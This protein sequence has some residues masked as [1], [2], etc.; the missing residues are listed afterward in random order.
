MSCKRTVADTYQAPAEKALTEDC[1]F[2][3]DYADDLA[4][5]SPTDV[6]QSSVWAI[7]GT[8]VESDSGFTDPLTW[9]RVSGGTKIG[10]IHRL[11]NTVVTAGGDTF[12]RT[13][14]VKI[15]NIHVKRPDPTDVEFVTPNPL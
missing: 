5:V 2:W 7:D 14:T 12:V 13:L 4:E 3:I 8:L 1:R 11:T 9:I 15:V 10:T 6:I